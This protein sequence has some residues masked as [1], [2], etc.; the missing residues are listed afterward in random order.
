MTFDVTTIKFLL[1]FLLRLSKYS[2]EGGWRNRTLIEIE[3]S[4]DDE[5]GLCRRKRT[6]LH[7]DFIKRDSFSCKR[8]FPVDFL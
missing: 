2:D 5:V 8:R 3:V 1:G 7:E 6:F 4:D